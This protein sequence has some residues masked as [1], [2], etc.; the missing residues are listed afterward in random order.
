MPSYVGSAL[1]A[2]PRTTEYAT[3][4]SAITSG[5]PVTTTT[6]GPK[7]TGVNSSCVTLV[8]PSV[9]SLDVTGTI[10]LRP[11]SELSPTVNIAVPPLSLVVS[12]MIGDTT[13]PTTSS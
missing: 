8:T 9:G 1:S 6:T 5:K 13:I 11:G 4:P 7:R 10:T 3:S 12:P 2:V